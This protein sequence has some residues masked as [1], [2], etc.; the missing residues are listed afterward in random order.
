MVVAASELPVPELPGSVPVLPPSSMPTV[1][2]TLLVLL[3]AVVN[4]RLPAATK[5]LM[6]GIDPTNVNTPVPDPLSVTPPPK[7]AE[8]VPVATENVVVPTA[9]HDTHTRK[10]NTGEWNGQGN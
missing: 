9:L 2:I 1:S 3:S 7:V 4:T 5:A 10:M 6:S 8:S